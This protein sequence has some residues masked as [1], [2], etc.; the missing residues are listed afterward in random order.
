MSW[1]L[2]Q[3]QKVHKDASN[4]F[5]YVKIVVVAEKS[6]IW[7]LEVKGKRK[8]TTKK[9]DFYLKAIDG[10]Y[11]A[12]YECSLYYFQVKQMLDMPREAGDN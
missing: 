4:H 1:V 7:G 8:K 2:C 10:T 9:Q 3:A 11:L 5:Q 6:V 12:T